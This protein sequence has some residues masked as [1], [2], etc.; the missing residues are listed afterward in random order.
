MLKDSKIWRGVAL[1]FFLAFCVGARAETDSLEARVAVLEEELQRQNEAAAL[2]KESDAKK[3]SAK[4]GGRF[5]IT[6]SGFSQDD[7]AKEIA[8]FESGAEI[9]RARISVAGDFLDQYN[10]KLEVDFSSGG[11][12]S[13]KDAFIGM[14]HLPI[15][16]D[17]R[18]GHFKEPI[19]LERLTSSNNIWFIER[20]AGC[21]MFDK[22]LFGRSLGVSLGNASQKKDFSWS[23]G[24]FSPVDDK[25]VEYQNDNDGYGL[26]LRIAKLLWEDSSVG[27]NLHVGFGYSYKSW[28]EKQSMDWA[29]E[30]ETAFAE[31]LVRTGTFYGTGA[32]HTFV[33]EFFWSLGS[34]AFQAEY[35]IAQLQNDSY[36]N[37]TFTGGYAQ[38][39]WMLS[40]EHYDYEKG[41]G[42]LKGIVP[43]AHF[44]RL[45]KEG[46]WCAGP[47][48]WQAIY[49][50]SWA[51]V[52]DLNTSMSGKVFDHTLG[53]NWILN[54]NTRVMFNYILSTNKFENRD[55]DAVVSAFVGAF[56]LHF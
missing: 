34:L 51:D 25:K 5:H 40:G 15:A 23:L 36:D 26:T 32:T 4:I 13:I 16:S 33:P 47:G 42:I 50:F 53:L 10:Y 1:L 17:L 37:P 3:P 19:S 45:C 7:A 41:R 6:T 27:G 54:S 28:D 31:T 12:V 35:F 49:R 55:D 56:Q 24:F 39:S 18:V 43:N 29:P 22:Y 30:L 8:D 2:K 21:S 11:D 48:A 52:S 38:V 14:T 20:S 44:A 46:I 9:R